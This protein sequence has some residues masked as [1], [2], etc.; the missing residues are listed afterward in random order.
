MNRRGVKQKKIRVKTNVTC[1]ISDWLSLLIVSE[2]SHAQ[3]KL[4]LFTSGI[5]SSIVH[6]DFILILGFKFS[7]LHIN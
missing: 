5:P 3:S 1:M 7:A 4:P 6:S 2:S